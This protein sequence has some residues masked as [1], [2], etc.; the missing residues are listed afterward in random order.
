MSV[1]ERC[2]MEGSLV[3]GFRTAAAGAVEGLHVA[4]R[5]SSQRSV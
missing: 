5:W 2:I 3:A 4:L 1:M